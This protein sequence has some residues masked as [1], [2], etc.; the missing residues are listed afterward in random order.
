LRGDPKSVECDRSTGCDETVL[1]IDDSPDD[2]F[3]FSKACQAA[4]VSFLLKLADG[5][6]VAREYLG[7]LRDYAD[8]KI[9]PLPDFILLDIKMPQMDGFEVLTW[10]RT[11]PKVSQTMVALYS[12][13]TVDKDVLRG[14]LTGT[15]YYIPKSQSFERLRE[16][17]LGLDEC[18]NS[19]GLECSRLLRLSID[20]GNI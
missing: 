17:V 10:I 14:Y 6:D 12:S 18:L 3:L 2:L 13:S 4:G 11:H 8:R 5:S 16:L 15:T 19:H 1:Y 20:P 7:G 9:H